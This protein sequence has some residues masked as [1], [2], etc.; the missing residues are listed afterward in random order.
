MV[1]TLNPE[2]INYLLNTPADEDLMRT[3]IGRRIMDKAYNHAMMRMDQGL[4]PFYQEGEERQDTGVPRAQ[5]IFNTEYK[6]GGVTWLNEYAQGGEIFSSGGEKHRVYKKESPTGN[7]KGVKGHIMVTHPTM[8]KGKWDTIDLTEKSGAKTIAQGVVATRKWHRENPEYQQGGPTT[9]YSYVLDDDSGNTVF[10][11]NGNPIII[12]P[13]TNYT[14]PEWLPQVNITAPRLPKPGGIPTSNVSQSNGSLAADLVLDAAQF[15]PG[16]LGVAASAVGVGKNLYEG[17]YVGAGL[18]LANIATLGGAK[19]FTLA[20]DLAKAAGKVN[21]GNRLA[22]QAKL[23]EHASNPNLWRTTG[24]TRDLLKVDKTG[25]TPTY[26]NEPKKAPNLI[27]KKDGGWLN[28]Y[29]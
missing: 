3:E 28:N 2:E 15:V 9:R 5:N 24:L 26:K 22:K 19:W 4:S 23:L 27:S 12:N 29:K 11:D 16:P 21:K 18:D 20:A 7:G 8:D 1:P 6:R 17:D 25:Y 10:D 13:T 14:V